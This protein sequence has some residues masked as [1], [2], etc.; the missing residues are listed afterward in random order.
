MSADLK[1]CSTIRLNVLSKSKLVHDK[2]Q[3]KKTGTL[4]YTFWVLNTKKCEMI[5]MNIQHANATKK[6]QSRRVKTV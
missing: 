6:T 5:A 3:H 4:H 1:T 2:F